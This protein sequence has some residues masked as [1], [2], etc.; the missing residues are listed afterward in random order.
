MRNVLTQP[1][2]WIM[3]TFFTFSIG[4]SFAIYSMMPLFLVSERG[5]SRELANMLTGLSRVAGL[6][7]LF[8]SG[9]IT[10]RAGHKRA[11]V[12]FMT[13][14]GAFI[15]LIGLIHSPGMTPLLVMLQAASAVCTFPAGFTMLSHEFSS[16]I[17][18][19]VVSLVIMIGYL[20]GGG[21]FP[22]GIGYI[23]ERSSFSWSF[24]LQGLLTLSIVPLLLKFHRRNG[25]R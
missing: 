24:S 10:D 2:F 12:L 11:M 3:T 14:T 16:P 21:A 7:T 18:N 20:L 25:T 23:A 19:L 22:W 4:A 9:W 5:M 15:L 17:R 1:G 13:A 6:L 8:A